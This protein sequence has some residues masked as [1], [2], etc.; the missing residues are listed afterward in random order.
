MA[1]SPQATE[2]IPVF[3]EGYFHTS[4]TEHH[5]TIFEMVGDGG[6]SGVFSN[7]L[8]LSY[9]K[10][11]TELGKRPVAARTFSAYVSTLMSLGLIEAERAPTRGN[12]RILR[13]KT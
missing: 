13:I 7:A 10:H 8:W 4:L 2:A 12:V 1:R 9:L 11:C 6:E 5:R 3:V